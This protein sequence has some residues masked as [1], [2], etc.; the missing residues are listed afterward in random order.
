MTD[1][2][3]NILILGVGNILMK[4]DGLGVHIV[5]HMI[6][7]DIA[8]PANVEVFEGGT[9][10]FDLL[11]V[12]TGRD[13]IIIID[14]LK[15]DDAPGTVYRFP[16]KHLKREPR[17]YSLH[18]TGVSGIIDMMKLLDEEPSVEIIGI[19]PGDIESLE[20][21]MSEPVMDAIPRVVEI[22]LEAVQ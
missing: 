1:A 12:M 19:V 16:A 13:R 21:G 4:D 2:L 22:I 18:D 3:K 6:D 11:N 9:L 14:A 17:S 10:G 7:S 15:T 5:N 20:I 8:L